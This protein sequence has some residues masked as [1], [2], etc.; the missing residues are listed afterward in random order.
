MVCRPCSV[1]QADR[2]QRMWQAQVAQRIEQLA[3]SHV[4]LPKRESR[5]SEQGGNLHTK[6]STNIEIPF[7][8]L[9]ERGQ[10]VLCT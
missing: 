6:K 1:G 9:S 5:H 8:A 3:A 2:V 10:L 4:R 7:V